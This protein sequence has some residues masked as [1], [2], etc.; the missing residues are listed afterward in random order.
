MSVTVDTSCQVMN[1]IG[2]I[3]LLQ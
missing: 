1:S 2:A 3:V